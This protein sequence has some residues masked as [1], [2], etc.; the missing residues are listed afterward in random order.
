V[1][2]S[3]HWADGIIQKMADRATMNLSVPCSQYVDDPAIQDDCI[4]APQANQLE[5]SALFDEQMLE[6]FAST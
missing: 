3:L 2:R 6:I 1:L 5:S 4:Q